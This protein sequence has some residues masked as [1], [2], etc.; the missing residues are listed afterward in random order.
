VIG[1]DRGTPRDGFW[2]NLRSIGLSGAVLLDAVTAAGWAAS[3][4]VEHPRE[5]HDLVDAIERA[6]PR[7]TAE[8]W[9]ALGL[10]DRAMD[11]ANRLQDDAVRV[12]FA[13]ARTG[14]DW[15][16][17]ALACAG[18]S[19]DVAPPAPK[20][21]DG[22]APAAA[23]TPFEGETIAEVVERS[24][25]IAEGPYGWL[26]L[27]VQTLWE[28]SPHRREFEQADHQAVDLLEHGAPVPAEVFGRF[29]NVR[30]DEVCAAMDYAGR[31]G[32]ALGKYVAL[33][34]PERIA[35]AR[36]LANLS[37]LRRPGCVLTVDE[38]EALRRRPG[39]SGESGDVDRISAWLRDHAL[40]DAP[41]AEAIARLL[42]DA[43]VLERLRATP[44]PA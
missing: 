21:A 2:S 11:F 17:R 10:R 13:L 36:A 3:E 31:L 25:A 42:A 7:F 35:R 28:E 16:H 20:L 40:A 41:P 15:P 18:L 32:Y 12:G 27:V 30:V 22:P 6:Q 4:L 5:W 9:V 34:G 14:E 26:E 43:D 19:T 1:H 39:E 8:E 33:P 44:T 23:A 37:M 24:G 38:W 29:D